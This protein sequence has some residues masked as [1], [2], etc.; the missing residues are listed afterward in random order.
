MIYIRLVRRLSPS[1]SAGGVAHTSDSPGSVSNVTSCVQIIKVAGEDV[2]NLS[3]TRISA[4]EMAHGCARAQ[5]RD[6]FPQSWFPTVYNYKNCSNFVWSPGKS[7]QL[8]QKAAQ[9]LYNDNVLQGVPY[10]LLQPFAT[11]LWD[12]GWHRLW[13]GAGQDLPDT[14]SPRRQNLH[15]LL[16]LRHE[17]PLI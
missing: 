16:P 4:E 1:P 9:C 8:S 14:T 17:N 10:K 11:G 2:W 13:N 6:M 5:L 3:D 12:D 15:I 7:T